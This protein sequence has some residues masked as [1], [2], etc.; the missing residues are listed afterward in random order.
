MLKELPPN[1][2]SNSIINSPKYNK[3]SWCKLKILMFVY[4]VKEITKNKNKK[5]LYME[6]IYF[7]IKLM[8]LLSKNSMI[9]YKYNLKLVML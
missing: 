5:P 2:I 3:I 1:K 9:V 8:T 4:K 6:D 7:W